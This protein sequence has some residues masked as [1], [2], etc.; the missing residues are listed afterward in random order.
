MVIDHLGL[1]FFP[2]QIWMRAVGRTVMPVFC[3]F[4]G[5]NFHQ[6]PRSII[7]VYGLIL[8]AMTFAIYQQFVAFNILIAI[9][10]GQWYLHLFQNQ[11][12]YNLYLYI[13][14]IFT[15]LLYL[16]TSDYMDYG[17]LGIAIMLIGFGAR[18]NDV[19][20][21][22]MVFSALVLSFFHTALIFSGMINLYIAAIIAI[23]EY[24]FIT[25]KDFTT[26]INIRF[27]RIF[28]RKAL[29]IYFVHFAII[30]IIF[31][32]ILMYRYAR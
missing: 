1:Y 28:S 10:L 22:L 5:Y 17:T 8:Y 26:L 27:Y 21:N 6:K 19:D 16:L 18:N 24:L 29:I 25:Y 3:F 7:L 11:L 20:R 15:S 2:E 9:Y 4:A 30:Q 23:A 12:Q 14:V 31:F 13:H 32:F